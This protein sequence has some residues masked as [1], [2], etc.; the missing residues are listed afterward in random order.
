[1]GSAENWWG[2]HPA[3]EGCQIGTP[4]PGIFMTPSLT[5][6]LS[7]TFIFKSSSGYQIDHFCTL[8]LFVIIVYLSFILAVI[9]LL[10]KKKTWKITFKK[11]VNYHVDE[12]QDSSSNIKKMKTILNKNSAPMM[13]L[14]SGANLV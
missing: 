6:S 9:L 12:L 14:R 1:M 2:Q 4:P 7:G 5:T 3:P 8:L 11:K 13:D 10:W